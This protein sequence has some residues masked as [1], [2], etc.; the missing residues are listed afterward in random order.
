M[1]F[2]GLLYNGA[3][4]IFS[5]N[6][7]DRLWQMPFFS[8]LGIAIILFVAAFLGRSDLGLIA[9]I[10]ANIFLYVPDT[11][12]YHKMILCMACAFGIITSFTL[13]LIGNTFPSLIPII[14]FLVTMISAQVVRYFS[15]GAPGFFFFTFAMIL[16]TYIPLKVEDY[17]IGYWS[18]SIRNDGC[19]CYGLI[20]CSKCYLYL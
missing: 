5:W 8:G 6:K 18:C 9:I 19:K 17:P 15:I 11:P 12:L 13:G 2:L 16:G 3:K 7:S 4:L 20:V 1:K 14:T 10:G